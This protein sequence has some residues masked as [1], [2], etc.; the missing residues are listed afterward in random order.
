MDAFVVSSGKDKGEMDIHSIMSQYLL[1]VA[2]SLISDRIYLTSTIIILGSTYIIA[3]FVTVSLQIN[4]LPLNYQM[5]SIEVYSCTQSPSSL[6][7]ISVA[8]KATLHK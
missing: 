6:T 5:S 3:L 2:P 7:N 1:I 8:F 4:K